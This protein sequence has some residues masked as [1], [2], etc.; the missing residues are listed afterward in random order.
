MILLKQLFW[1][2]FFITALLAR[3]A[4]SNSQEAT[5][6]SQSTTTL[7][8]NTA[9]KGIDT[10][11]AESLATFDKRLAAIEHFRASF[12]QDKKTPLLRNP[13]RSS[14]ILLA[15]GPQ[16]RWNTTEP[17]ASVMVI[18]QR[19][20]HNEIL[21]YYA[22]DALLEIHPLNHELGRLA[23][24]PLPSFRELAQ[25]YSIEKDPAALTDERGAGLGL[26]LVPKDEATRQHLQQLRLL[27]D[28]TTGLIWKV[29]ITEEEGSQTLLT[30]QELDT[31]TPVT[32]EALELN[33]P[34]GTEVIRT[35]PEPVLV[36]SGE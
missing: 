7:Q 5:S 16:M 13:M 3:P 33:V 23:G 11:L 32:S 10:D 17:Y 35:S 29:E 9:F 30:F 19:P 26:R 22:E 21:F 36:P 27:V 2:L 8:N 4:T 1:G 12:I 34:I 6:T 31:K 25:H 14:G 18:D 20:G 24:F 15:Q 28:S